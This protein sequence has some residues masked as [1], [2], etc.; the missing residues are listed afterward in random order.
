MKAYEAIEIQED[1]IK[2]NK[3][4]K[5]L[6]ESMKTLIN[7]YTEVMTELGYT[8]FYKI[9]NAKDYGIP[10]NREKSLYNFNKK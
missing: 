3:V 6:K 4:D 10:Q 2:D 1:Y 5:K 7:S 8:S 9:L